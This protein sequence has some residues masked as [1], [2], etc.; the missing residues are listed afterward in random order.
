MSVHHRTSKCSSAASQRELDRFSP[1]YSHAAAIERSELVERCTGVPRGSIVLLEA[2]AGYGK[3]ILLHQWFQKCRQSDYSVVYVSGRASGG[4]PHIFLPTILQAITAAVCSSSRSRAVP[5]EK[6]LRNEPFDQALQQLL[7]TST[8]PWTILIDDYEKA[9]NQATD[10]AIQ[11]LLA[12]LPECAVVGIAT[13]RRLTFPLTRWILEGRHT[14]VGKEE[15]QF[16]REQVKQ[17]FDG[18]L[19]PTEVQRLLTFTGGWPAP[20]KLAEVCSDKWRGDPDT[21]RK[22]P[23]YDRL[24]RDFVTSEILSCLSPD[25]ISLLIDCSVLDEIEPAVC[26]AVRQTSDSFIRLSQLFGRETFLEKLDAKSGTFRMPEVMRHSLMGIAA[27]RQNPRV[28]ALFERAAEAY[29]GRGDTLKAV[30]N[31]VS[32]GKAG[33]AAHT[34][35]SAGPLEIAALIGDAYAE[36]IFDL[37]PE[38]LVW[39]LPRLVLCRAYLDY[40]KG[41]LDTARHRM[42]DLSTLTKDFTVDRD[43]GDP[44]RLK[45]EA[46]CTNLV[47]NFHSVAS[48]SA[49]RLGQ[50]EQ[51]ISEIISTAP[52]M[53]AIGHIIVGAYYS[54]RGD[55][56]D[57][58]G[59]FM[60]CEKLAMEAGGAWLD[61]WL[62]YQRS[63]AALAHGQMTEVKNGLNLALKICRKEL[64]M[65]ERLVP[66]A[67]VL[68]AAVDY[69][70][71]SLNDARAKL[72]ESRDLT[73]NIEGWHEHYAI[74]L[75]LRMM[76]LLHRRRVDEAELLLEETEKMTP[77]REALGVFL[78]LLKF[79]L[80]LFQ[81]ENLP[82]GLMGDV[83]NLYQRWADAKAHDHFSW[84]S[85]DIAG[86]CLFHLNFR[87][88]EY[89]AAMDILG[90]ME[91]IAMR[92]RR[93][94]L[95]VKVFLLRAAVILHDRPQEAILA[96]SHGLE[97]G[98]SQGYKRAIL[99]E[100]LAIISVLEE[101]AGAPAQSL[102]PERVR[103]F[104]V[105]LL[106]DMPPDDASAAG[107]SGVLSKREIDVIHEVCRGSSNKIIG[108]KLAL[109]EPTVKFHLQNIFRKLGV[110]RRGAA[111]AEAKRLRLIE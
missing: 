104:A 6:T 13:Q 47:L 77:V 69:E 51:W 41:L 52:R 53:R 24:L 45:S 14:Q 23:Q 48:V 70:G 103:A 97:V 32:G 60:Q 54:M 9:Q 28:D 2:P 66:A 35:E 91:H 105:K 20:V 71:N 50:A 81:G 108:R 42:D 86:L 21:I 29:A 82:S 7:R 109:T 93:T 56:D 38:Q 67:N 110:H 57:S 84:R 34:F 101:V 65:S 22:I 62:K 88:A 68:L 73:L 33:R 5:S 25:D 43:G 96:A 80:A 46:G 37:L 94:Q 4:N 89:A 40:R 99:D 18:H 76:I 72:E 26:D 83:S 16:S 10:E 12:H 106:S 15:L 27:E 87:S 102:V 55:F 100:R 39:P 49:E 30:R 59:H 8:R 107:P 64:L 36:A 79:R 92:Q 17:L 90:R 11:A 58:E 63:A 19:T 44:A 75:E 61:A 74:E 98:M 1:R 111:I 31:F 78:Q 95:L 3:S 85:W